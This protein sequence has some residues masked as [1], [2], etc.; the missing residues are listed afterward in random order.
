MRSTDMMQITVIEG[1]Y[2]KTGDWEQTRAA[3]PAAAHPAALKRGTELVV[4]DGDTE[5]CAYIHR[6]RWPAAQTGP[7][8]GRQSEWATLSV[9]HAQ[10]QP[11]EVSVV[12]DDEWDVRACDDATAERTRA[13]RQAQVERE[14]AKA[15]LR[16]E[17]VA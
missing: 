10:A 2:D 12:V 7:E 8:P 5:R 6:I 3:Y 16:L 11:V 9:E 4:R 14:L 17:G 13:I 1:R 15:Q